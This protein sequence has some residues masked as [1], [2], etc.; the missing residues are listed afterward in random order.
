MAV[1]DYAPSTARTA[2]SEAYLRGVRHVRRAV[3]IALAAGGA[4]L[5]A[6][7]A[8][9]LRQRVVE[10]EWRFLFPL[11]V[12]V[13]GVLLALIGATFWAGPPVMRFAFSILHWCV[14][15][16]VPRSVWNDAAFDALWRLPWATAAGAVL[17]FVFW[18]F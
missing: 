11:E 10:G 17:L 3:L 2:P 8:H 15:R 7:L 16:R 1:L 12:A 13:L 18:A 6:F 14:G 5:L 9:R 4:W